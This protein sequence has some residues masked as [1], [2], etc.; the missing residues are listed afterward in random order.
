ME[1]Q[2]ASEVMEE[3]LKEIKEWGV[4]G[5]TEVF[6]SNFLG[7]LWIAHRVFW[8]AKFNEML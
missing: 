6:A 5:A 1:C 2:E 4:E 7:V 8:F 3:V